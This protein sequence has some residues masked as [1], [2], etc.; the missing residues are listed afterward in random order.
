MIIG[1]TTDQFTLLASCDSVYLRKYS[2]GLVASSAISANNLHL[3]VTNP[4]DSDLKYLEYLQACYKS[5]NSKEV[6]TTSYDTMPISHLDPSQKQA[7][8]ASNRFIIAPEIARGDLL[9]IDVD[10]L[11]IN[12][13]GNLR[14]DVGL[15][16]RSGD[17]VQKGVPHWGKKAKLIMA[18]AVYCKLKNIDFL[19]TARDFINQNQMIWHVDQ[20]ALFS[21]YKQY[22]KILTFAKFDHNLLDWHFMPG[23]LIWSGKNQ[24]KNQNIKYLQKYNEIVSE[25]EIKEEDYLI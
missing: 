11:I 18:G 6:M 19:K 8:Y 3:H 9:I 7:F 1:N 10:S 5:L 15:Y 20:V 17:V 13:I 22:K 14:E 21:A 25:I 12:H 16:F 2:K 24:A 4:N 23:T